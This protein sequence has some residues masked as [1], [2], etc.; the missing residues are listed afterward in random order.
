MCNSLPVNTA[1]CGQTRLI[2]SLH[3]LLGLNQGS[4][5]L[6]AVEVSKIDNPRNQNLHSPKQVS[7]YLFWGMGRRFYVVYVFLITNRGQLL[8]HVTGVVYSKRTV[9]SLD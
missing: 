1:V 8:V 2:V 5:A 4:H 3:R 9:T 6:K 7:H